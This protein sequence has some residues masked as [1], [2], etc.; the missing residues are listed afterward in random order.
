[1]FVSF[2][3]RL[4]PF[5][6]QERE[7]LRQF[8]EL[9]FLWNHALER[10]RDAW[11]KEKR[12][13]SYVSQCRDLTRWRAFDTGGV[14]R[15]NAQVAQETLAR[16]NDAFRHFFRRV[17]TGE[18]PGFP[19]FKKEVSSLTYPQAY[20]SVGIVGGRN[21]TW[22]LH[23]S[24]VGDLPIK[25][26]RAPPEERI[27]TCT[28]EHEGDRWFA[29]LTYEVP[30]PAPPSGDPISPVGV[31]LGLT[32]LAVLSDGEAVEA[33]KFLRA[34]EK[35]LSRAQRVVSR[36]KK[37]SHRRE[38]AKVRLARCHAKVRDQRRD[39]AHKVTTGW[40]KRHDLV[41]FEDLSVPSMLGNGR[42]SKA[43]S[44]AGWGMLRRMSEYKEARRS[45]RYVEVPA[46]GTTQTCS[47]CGRL[48]DPPLTL[49]DRTYDCPCGLRLD[50]NLNAA[51][52]VLARALAAV[53][54]GTGES[55]PVETGPPPHRKG[56]R[57]RSKKR[58]PPPTSRVA[59]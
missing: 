4:Y 8:G 48:H 24:K 56:R 32:H 45:G 31:D 52:N 15:V 10:R 25:V 34:S 29:V 12:P 14:G 22:R 19:R 50:R 3:F 55:T 39:F 37:G 5:P 17:K 16:L 42:L 40:A 54:G 44:D 27:K 38:K 28:V 51:R 20:D 33:P 13:V 21:G 47:G 9:R 58:E 11:R 53:P 46:K 43:V 6:N 1:M 36:R 49:K 2:K 23:L 35:R 41:A 30:D 7:L 18:R 59:T 26:H 57:V